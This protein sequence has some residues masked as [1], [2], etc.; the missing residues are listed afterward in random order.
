KISHELCA[1]SSL[2]AVDI[3]FE[4]SNIHSNGLPEE[5]YINK[6]CPE[7]INGVT[8]PASFSPPDSLNIHAMFLDG[9]LQYRKS[10]QT[11]PVQFNPEAMTLTGGQEY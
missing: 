4:W 10:P 5:M 6:Y 7:I 2:Y 8:V 11:V 1:S 3:N 9:E